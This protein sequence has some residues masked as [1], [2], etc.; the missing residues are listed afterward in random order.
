MIVG[1]VGSEQAKFTAETEKRAR[2]VIQDIL[3][4][5]GVTAMCSGHCHLGG[6]DI[7]AENV[8]DELGLKKIVYPPKQYNWEH[9]YKPRNLQIAKDS[10]IVYCITLAYLPD[11]YTGMRFKGC[12]HC[13][14]HP[15]GCKE[16]HV[17]SGGCW[18]AL[19]CKERKWIII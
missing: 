3:R 9:G 11:T 13:Q 12:Y 16:F 8:A 19:R 2:E 1:I 14:K 6:V 4:M 18:T 10:D 7:F 15:L 17:K 5:P